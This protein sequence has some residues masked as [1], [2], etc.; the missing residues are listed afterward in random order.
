VLLSGILVEQ[1][2]DIIAL[3]QRRGF[4]LE[5]SLDRETGGAQWRTLLLRKA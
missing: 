5:R 4:A 2:P 1:A 3:Y